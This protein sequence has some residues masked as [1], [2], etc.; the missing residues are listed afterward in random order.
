MHKMSKLR[1]DVAV[2]PVRF[3]ARPSGKVGSRSPSHSPTRRHGR[4]QRE[5]DPLLDG[6]SPT[7]T[8]EA[9]RRTWSTSADEQTALGLL[10]DS[11]AR[12]SPDDCAI[13]LKAA[14]VSE[15]A[16]Q[17][18]AELSSWQWPVVSDDPKATGFELP[19]AEERA[20]K[21]RK[22]S[23][24]GEHRA[25]GLRNGGEGHLGQD[26]EEYW[27]GCPAQLVRQREARLET[28]R[29]GIEHLG[30]EELKE[31]VLSEMNT[32]SSRSD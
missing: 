13:A 5:V 3:P 30:M 15:R 7:T 32:I 24:F 31:R 2:P 10:D 12:A 6:L 25:D 14:T 29:D 9:L 22:T 18:Y 11:I 17:W 28:I 27:G 21:R 20:R 23:E 4:S 8:L 26:D 19:T 1:P 16:R